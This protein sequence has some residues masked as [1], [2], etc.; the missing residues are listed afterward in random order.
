M[1]IAGVGSLF[2]CARAGIVECVEER[3]RKE[4]EDTGSGHEDAARGY[5]DECLAS[6]C[7]AESIGELS[8][9]FM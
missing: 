7:L 2:G 5:N 6:T 9:F 4:F 1:E 3:Y 8:S